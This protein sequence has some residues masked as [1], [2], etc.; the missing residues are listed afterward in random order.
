MKMTLLEEARHLPISERI[1]LV[2]AIWD[3]VDEDAGTDAMPV[4]AAHPLESTPNPCE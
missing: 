3:T 1:E 2:E 4:S